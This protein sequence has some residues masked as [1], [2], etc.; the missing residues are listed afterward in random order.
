M[1]GPEV[2]QGWPRGGPA[3]AHPENVEI[4][5]CERNGSLWVAQRWSRGGPAVA[6]GWPTRKVLKFQCVQYD[7]EHSD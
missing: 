5:M 4:S 2:V 6:Q 3:V 7:A 1:G